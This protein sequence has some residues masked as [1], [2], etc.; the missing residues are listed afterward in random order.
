[1]AKH[2]HYDTITAWAKGETIEMYHPNTNTW[3]SLSNPSWLDN[4]QYR[5]KLKP[6]P[7]VTHEAL[8]SLSFHAG[9]LLHPASPSEANCVL[10]FDG[11]T[12]KLT[13]VSFKQA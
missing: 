11:D 12:G 4:T 6:K 9:P 13:G 2:K 8:I 5:V 3:F 7:P 1:M 10:V